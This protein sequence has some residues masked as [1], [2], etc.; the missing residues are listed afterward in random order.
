MGG[1]GVAFGAIFEKTQLQLAKAGDVV[2][3]KDIYDLARITAVRP[4]GDGSF[5]SNVR[6]EFRL[7]CESRQIYCD[8]LST[9][10]EQLD[11]AEATYN[12]DATLPKDIAFGEA[13]AATRSVVQLLE[14]A[15]LFPLR[16]AIP[17]R[18]PSPT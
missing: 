8:G 14:H 2:R 18:D 4:L 1:F 15:G 11:V 3:A 9:F 6:S 16:F 5:W 7:V 13:W 17:D 10:E 12:A